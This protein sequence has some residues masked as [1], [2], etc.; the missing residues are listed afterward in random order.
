VFRRVPI[1]LRLALS[2]AAF[3]LACMSGVGFYLLASLEVQLLQEIND[4]LLLR[5][6]RVVQQLASGPPDRLH[7]EEVSQELLELTPQEEFSTPGV[8]IQV[9]D[10]DGDV[11]AA[12]GNL[13]GGHLPL[14]AEL[15]GR[16]LA[17]V[18][19]YDTLEVASERVRVLVQPVVRGARPVGVV[20]VGESLHLIDAAL[21][22]L[23]YLL[24]AS[25]SIAALLAVVGAWWLT[26][27]ALGPI[28]DVVRLARHIGTTRRF[29][30]RIAEPPA[31]DE[32]RELTTTI[33]SMLEAIEQGFQRQQHFLADVSHEL[34]GP[35]MVV[36]GNLDL[37]RLGL[38]DAE[39]RAAVRDALEEVEHVGALLADLLFLLEADA[40]QSVEYQPVPLEAVVDGVWERALH[41]DRGAH[42]L[43]RQ[44][45]RSVIVLGDRERLTQMLWNLVENALRYTPPGG[46][47]AVALRVSDAVAELSVTDSGMGIPAEHLPRIFDRFYRVDRARSR[48]EGGTG[49]GLAIVQQIAAIHGGQVHVWS[50]PGTGSRFSATLPVWSAAA[51]PAESRPA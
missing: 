40:R 42:T 23:Q 35:L 3:L 22:R 9:L 21:R 6:S 39:R 33:N 47:V 32:L 19:A 51:V 48:Q 28:A 26:G 36:R 16:A 30:Q 24:L 44:V 46:R 41:L 2:Y 12:S 43:E 18:E 31:R 37:M 17:G 49:L 4:T 34:R 14:T 25:A 7:V 15:V 20:A 8:Y 27:R 38:P 45:E 13:H 1:R 11:L 29:D 50:E 10:P 5:A